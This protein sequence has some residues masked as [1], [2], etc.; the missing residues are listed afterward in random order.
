MTT[1]ERKFTEDDVFSDQRGRD[2]GITAKDW[3]ASL[4]LWVECGCDGDDWQKIEMCDGGECMDIN[5]YLSGEVE[6]HE[7]VRLCAYRI[8]GPDRD[9]FYTTDCTDACGSAMVLLRPENLRVLGD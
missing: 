3:V 9:G 2:E 5:I 8:V 7:V 6:D 1:R 4:E